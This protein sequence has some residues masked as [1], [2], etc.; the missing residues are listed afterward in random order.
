VQVIPAVDVYR[1]E[2][3]RLLR[4]DYDQ[5][6]VYGDDPVAMAR[7]WVERGA[8]LVHV[9]DLEG[10]RSGTPDHTLWERLGEAGVPFQVGGGIRTADLARQAVD[11]GAERVVLGSAAVWEPEVLEDL[12]GT[13]GAGR[14]VAA[15]DVRGDRATG[16]GWTD[17]GR[18]LDEVVAGVVGAGCRWVLAT[19]ISRDG[20]LEG[21]DVGLVERLLEAAPDLRVI[22]SGGVGT[23]EDLR[24]LAAAGAA[25]VVVGRAL[26][27]EEFTLSEA[28]AFLR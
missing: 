2:V 9:V 16:A 12:V 7:S 26:Y 8:D 21:P 22:G 17:R 27:D 13:L 24:A 15:L 4:G 5:V 23:L 20:T 28:L 1:G 10:A 19:G 6:T 14:V 18:S 11:A 25:A 3:V